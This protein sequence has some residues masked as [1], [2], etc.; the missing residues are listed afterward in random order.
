MRFSG[1]QHFGPPESSGQNELASVAA[2]TP[3]KMASESS[4]FLKNTLFL[5]SGVVP[6]LGQR[7]F[8]VDNMCRGQNRYSLVRGRGDRTMSP[9][10]INSTI[11]GRLPRLPGWNVTF[12]AG[13][14]RLCLFRFP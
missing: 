11:D 14:F 1:N 13:S 4:T 12:R 9:V 2:M 6:V 7:K 10:P 5:V 8:L 3:G